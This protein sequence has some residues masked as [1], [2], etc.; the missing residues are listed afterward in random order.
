V[1]I[2]SLA[3]RVGGYVR[4]A[5]YDGREMT[6][7]ARRRF[8]ESF[9]EGH[10]CRVCPTVAMPDGLLPGERARRAEALRRAHYARVALASA[11]ARSRRKAGAEIP[12]PAPAVDI[13]D[14]SVDFP[15]AA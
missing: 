3:G 11:Q 15:P 7:A 10:G 8:A 4:A 13:D 6:A 5:R 2:H 14:G 9:L 1:S 12:H